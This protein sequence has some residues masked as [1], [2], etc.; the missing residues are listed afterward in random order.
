MQHWATLVGSYPVWQI[1]CNLKVLGRGVLEIKLLINWKINSLFL[2]R[3]FL[4]VIG[5]VLK[6]AL[7]KAQEELR[8]TYQV[9]K[10]E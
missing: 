6:L 1:W 9:T 2:E 5:F 7:V 4:N 3:L 10:L 8:F